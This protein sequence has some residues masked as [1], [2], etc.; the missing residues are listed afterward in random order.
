MI[1]SCTYSRFSRLTTSILSKV[2]TVPPEVPHGIWVTLSVCRVTCT[3]EGSS[4]AAVRQ[5]KGGREGGR[6]RERES[7]GSGAAL[8]RCGGAARSG[9][10]AVER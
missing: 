2:I 9:G 1:V 7:S 4:A 10:G 8:V 3:C 6:E 5:R